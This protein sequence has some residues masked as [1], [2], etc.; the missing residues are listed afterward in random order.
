MDGT[1]RTMNLGDHK[2]QYTVPLGLRHYNQV[3]RLPSQQELKLIRLR[4]VLHGLHPSVETFPYVSIINDRAN[5]GI[6][7]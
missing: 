5:E 2:R 4:K 1:D 6:V 3:M 7:R